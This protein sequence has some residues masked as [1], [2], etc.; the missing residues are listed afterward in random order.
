MILSFGYMILI[1]LLWTFVVYFQFIQ[2]WFIYDAPSG[3]S[4]PDDVQ[5]F[6]P[7]Q[8][9][10]VGVNF[11]PRSLRIPFRLLQVSRPY[12]VLWFG[13]VSLQLQLI[14]F[15][16]GCLK[17]YRAVP[18]LCTQCR[19]NPQ[20]CI[21][22]VSLLLLSTTL[23][24][25]ILYYGNQDKSRMKYDNLISYLMGFASPRLLNSPYFH[26]EIESNNLKWQQVVRTYIFLS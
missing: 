16:R 7:Q 11:R 20:K 6:K 22:R 8:Q 17:L 19:D 23:F 1:P 12:L 3:V 18:K 4:H 2:I 14:F 24:T 26:Y 15:A 10:S 25:F 5:H 21:L 13:V 9:S